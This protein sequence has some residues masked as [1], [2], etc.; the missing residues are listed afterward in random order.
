MDS[1]KKQSNTTN[2]TKVLLI[3]RK[4]AEFMLLVSVGVE[5]H[6]YQQ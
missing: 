4:D 3:S 2:P 5:L 1:L 6:N